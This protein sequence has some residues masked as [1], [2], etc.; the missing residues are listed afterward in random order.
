[1]SDFITDNVEWILLI[2]AYIMER[3][4]EVSRRKKMKQDVQDVETEP[5]KVSPAKK[6]AETV[7]DFLPLISRVTRRKK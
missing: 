2:V 4:Q 6:V 3:L 1:M 5:R 7:I